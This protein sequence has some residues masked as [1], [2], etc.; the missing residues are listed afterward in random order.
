MMNVLIFILSV[1]F[2]TRTLAAWYS[3]ADHWYHL[4]Q[5]WFRVM[6]RILLWTLI[7]VAVYLVL[8]TAMR[9]AMLWG[10]GAFALTHVIAY[11]IG[12]ILRMRIERNS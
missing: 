3:L 1:H 12:Q 7:P 9:E 2:C 8:P 10:Y 11:G 5:A 6:L 4:G